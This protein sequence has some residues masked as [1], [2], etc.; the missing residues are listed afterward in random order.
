MYLKRGSCWW[1]LPLLLYEKRIDDGSEEAVEVV[2]WKGK[3]K[4]IIKNETV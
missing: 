2:T 4:R 3:Q 1:F